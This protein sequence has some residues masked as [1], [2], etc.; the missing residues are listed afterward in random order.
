AA[1]QPEAGE[2]EEEAG[3][4]SPTA[5]AVPPGGPGGEPV[6]GGE[7]ENGDE[8]SAAPAPE[9]REKRD[10]APSPAGAATPA[11]DVAGERREEEADQA[12]RR[13]APEPGAPRDPE[14]TGERAPKEPEEVVGEEKAPSSE[15]TEEGEPGVEPGPPEPAAEKPGAEKPAPGPPTA[16]APEGGRPLPPRMRGEAEKAFG[17]DFS[18]VRLHTGPEGER[19][20][21]DAG[22]QAFTR[23]RDV[24]MGERMP[25]PETAAG[26]TVLQHEL[27]HVVQQEKGG[28]TGEG[29]GGRAEEAEG[30]RR[31]EEEKGG[32]LAGGL[33]PAPEGVQA[34]PLVTAVN[35][36]GELGVGR[37]IGV[38]AQLTPGSPRG[39]RLD[40][41]LV[42]APAGVTIQGRGRRV[43]VRA[44]TGVPTLTAA[45]GTFQVQATVH[46]APLDTAISAPVMLVGIT[47]VGFVPTPEFPLMATAIPTTGPPDTGEPNR[48]GVTGNTVT[49]NAVTAP[50]GRPVT[51]RLTR[52]LGATAAGNVVTPGRTTGNIRVRI[53]DDATA[54]RRDATLPINP[55]PLRLRGFGAQIDAVPAGLYGCQN[56][57]RFAPSDRANPLTRQVGETIAVPR[58]DL[59]LAPVLNTSAG[60]PNPAPIPALTAP[61]DQWTDRLF[62]PQVLPPGAAPDAN[63]M[64][65]N[66]YVGPGV[67]ATLPRVI[68]IR[69]GFHWWSWDGA[70]VGPEFDR[71]IHRRSLIRT[72]ANAFAFRTEHIFPGARARADDDPYVSP[73][74]GVASPLIILSNV[75]SA[76]AAPAA[77]RLAADGTAT[78]NVTVVGTHPGRSV[79]WSVLSGPG[80]FTAAAATANPGG[81]AATLQAGAAPGRVRVRVEDAVFP[82]RRTEGT[83]RVVPVRLL[84][85][86]PAVRSV[87][88]GTLTM[89]VSVDADPG[90]RTLSWT[91]DP[92]AAAAGVAVAPDA[93]PALAAAARTATVTRPAGFTGTVTV[94]ASDSVLTARTASTTVRFR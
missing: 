91:V 82:N 58:D 1:A 31:R 66:M 9:Q 18:R 30:G 92:A 34:L 48:D 3:G 60:G 55:V 8:A 15:A 59:G 4:G 20:A 50:A 72:G 36:P 12:A 88:A 75:A 23:G 90:G 45:G 39:T 43:T 44:G 29:E 28:R 67:A 64:N 10:E 19:A 22:A 94:T 41:S 93:I 86:R 77:A 52:A 7:R 85:M 80:A 57:L 70:H 84:R 47:A 14:T 81:T 32:G 17:W 21:R 49:V 42:G 54:S 35:A 46:G 79:N 62:T 24:V 38:E 51:V 25:E 87:P 2:R 83:I 5:A 68:V 89:V 13:A 33:S 74:A 6:N 69:Q 63:T 11:A 26:K 37:S 71:G 65:V 78:A 40:W 27:A 53:T 76:P 73:Y 16:R 56:P 61:A